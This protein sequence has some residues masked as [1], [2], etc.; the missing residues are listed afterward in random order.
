MRKPR[1]DSV[2]D[3][4][5]PERR[6]QLVR[7]LVEENLK[8]PEAVT[9]VWEKFG[10]KT[11]VSALQKFYA[12]RCFAL[13][14]DQ[15]KDFADLVVA[16]A[17]SNPAQFDEATLALVKQKAFE[18]VYARDGNL[19]ELAILAGILGDSAKLELKRQELQLADRRVAL[20][21]KKAALADQAQGVVNDSTITEEQKAA[22]LREI[23]RM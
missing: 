1:S 19:N 5:P 23:F 3:S 7:W 17:K 18:R 21:E 10:V 12:R 13:R 15:A 8:Y 9:R 16:E 11:S 6:E 22:R 20:L 4:L 14:A 2:L